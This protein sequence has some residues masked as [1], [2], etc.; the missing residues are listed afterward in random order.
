[1]SSSTESAPD[2]EEAWHLKQSTRYEYHDPICRPPTT[3]DEIAAKSADCGTEDRKQIDSM[4]PPSGRKRA[5]PGQVV[6]SESQVV[7]VKFKKSHEAIWRIQ[8]SS[9]HSRFVA[10]LPKAYYG[11]ARDLAIALFH[12]I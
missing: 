6:S 8:S 1:M 7:A 12:N 5:R 10:H 3:D 2:E 11:Q 4:F 9:G